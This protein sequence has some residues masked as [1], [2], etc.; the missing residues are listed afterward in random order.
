MHANLLT[1]LALPLLAIAS[2]LLDLRAETCDVPYQLFCSDV[3]S[4]SFC[5]PSGTVLYTGKC[6]Q[7]QIID[8]NGG[9]TTFC[10][11]ESTVIPTV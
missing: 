7:C 6:T 4:V 10:A 1:L 9:Q 8:L 2:P 5:G 11:P 3:D